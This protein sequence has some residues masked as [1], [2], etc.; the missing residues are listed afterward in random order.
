MLRGERHL[1]KFLTPRGKGRFRSLDLLNERSACWG[2]EERECFREEGS[3]EVSGIA[4]RSPTL[5]RGEAS[6]K[7]T[8]GGG[9]SKRPLSKGACPMGQEAKKPVE[10]SLVEV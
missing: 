7:C 8:G 6:V 3:K 2:V 10:S 1:K 4:R 5:R 9:V